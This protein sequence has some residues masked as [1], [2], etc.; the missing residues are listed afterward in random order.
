VIASGGADDSIFLWCPNAKTRRV[1]YRF[2][3]R[4]GITV[5][6]FGG[7]GGGGGVEPSSSA[8]VREGGGDWMLVS[9]GADGC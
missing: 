2:A 8:I 1:Q 3:H 5:L 6:G 7:G 9:A 4:G